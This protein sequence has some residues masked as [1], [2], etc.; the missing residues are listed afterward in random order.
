MDSEESS[1]ER[2]KRTLYSRDEKLVP[3]EKRTPVPGRE[4]DTPTSWGT[5]PSFDISPEA[6]TKKNNSFFNKFLLW[7][8]AFF[9]VSLGIALFIFFGGINMIS[10]NNVDVKIIA[11]SSVSSG[12]ELLVTLSFVNGNR[13]DLEDVTLFIDYPIGSQAVGAGGKNLTHESIPLG[14][15]TKGS[16]K[17]YTTRSLLF[18]EKDAIKT[19]I[20]RLEYKVKGSNAV[21]SKEKNYTVVIGS[22]PVLLNVD[23]PKELT[24]G[25][26]MTLTVDV[27]SNSSVVIKNSLVKVEYPYGFTYKSSN[28]S[29]VRDNSIWNVGDLKN[30]DKKTLIIKG[31][32]VGQDLEDRSFRVSVGNREE[33]TVSDLDTTLAATVL[34]V[35]IRKSFFDLVVVTDSGG[36]PSVQRS[37]PISIKWQNTLP[38]KVVNNNVEVTL[39]GNALDRSSVSVSNGG[40]YKSVDN[41][42]VWDKNNNAELLSILPGAGGQV[43]F[44]VTSLNQSQIRSVRNPHIDIGIVMMGDR[45]GIDVVPIS[46]T[47]DITIKI[48]STLT[49]SGKN[50]RN[51]GPFSNSGPVP[52]KADQETTYTIT[53]TL[54]N[55]TSDLKD[56]VVKTSLPNGVAWKGETSPTGERISYD[57]DSNTVSWN[58]GNISFGAGFTNSPREV[59]FK[60]GITPS[61]TQVGSNP[62]LTT[63]A[64]VTA[65]DTYAEIQIK[66]SAGAVSTESSDQ[67]FKIGDGMV[68][69]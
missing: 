28:M 20:F 44:S 52:P 12:E 17:D 69:P 65:N 58:A 15:I 53:W 16:I 5:K 26:E 60:V 57:P 66:T 29:P 51:T 49:L 46:S 4:F 25:K 36:A 23:Y 32:L 13:A 30:G 50:F 14:T 39:G 42:I 54:T 18:G 63:E 67:G 2:L 31:I 10:S 8:L 43:Y 48:P 55:T 3:K 34:T 61:V 40:F 35:G 6:M 1:I 59:S 7:S 64:L 62:I 68:Q 56:T 45:S 27:T 22:S 41:T 9:F 33:G 19:I 47:K 11:P 38:D 37:I 24:S 21:F